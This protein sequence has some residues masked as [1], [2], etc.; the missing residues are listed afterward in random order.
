MTFSG[1]NSVGGEH[2]V[3]ENR[4]HSLIQWDWCVYRIYIYILLLV[5]WEQPS[6]I[7]THP[8][9]NIAISCE[10]KTMTLKPELTVHISVWDISVG[11]LKRRV[12]RVPPTPPQPPPYPTPPQPQAPIRLRGS[13]LCGHFMLVCKGM[14]K[15]DPT[16]FY[17]QFYVNSQAT[18]G[19]AQLHHTIWGST[20]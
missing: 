15:L 17:F 7:L 12:F 19:S 5:P 4:G 2:A 8:P 20:L 10:E 9:Q 11:P 16:V 13:P 6:L 18:T 3:H 14:I 1:G